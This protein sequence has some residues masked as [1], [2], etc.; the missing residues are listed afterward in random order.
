M[1]AEVTLMT[2]STGA[3]GVARRHERKLTS[4]AVR[5]L[6][7]LTLLVAIGATARAQD[8]DVSAADRQAIRQIIQRQVDAFRRDDAAEA[9]SYAS[10]EIQH[11]FGTSEIF[12]DMVRQGYRPVYRPRVFDF[13][14]VVTVNGQPTQKVRVIGPDGRPVT[15][16]YPMRR[17]PDGTWRIDG[18]FLQAP[19]EHQA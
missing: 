1:R 6:A 15:A 8:V 16:F 13:E 3:T 4:M 11:L 5:L 14:E 10:P 19:E 18:C 2:Y 12:M 9:F 7:L 17:L